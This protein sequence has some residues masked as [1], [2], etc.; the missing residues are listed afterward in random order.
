MKKLIKKRSDGVEE[1][2]RYNMCRQALGQ[3]G[4]HLTSTVESLAQKYVP[5]NI[6]HWA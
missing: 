6:D 5:I 3:E 2:I 4:T 1:T